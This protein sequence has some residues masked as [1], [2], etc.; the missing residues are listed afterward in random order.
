MNLYRIYLLILLAVNFM[1]SAN[2]IAQINAKKVFSFRQIYDSTEGIELYDKFNPVAGGDSIRKDTTGHPINIIVEDHYPDGNILHKGSYQ[3]GITLYYT[4]FY[5]DG[6]TERTFRALSEKKYEMK[7]YYQN[8]LL[9]SDLIFYESKTIYW[10]EYYPNNQLSYCEEYD[11]KHKQLLKR[12]SYYMD[13]KPQ[14]LFVPLP[15]SKKEKLYSLKDYFTNGQ[16]EED[17]LFYYNPETF[18]FVKHGE[19]KEYDESGK[20]I[21]DIEYVRGEVNQ[22][23]K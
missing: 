6:R 22:T 20:L 3:N 2:S 8:S 1:F 17:A 10:C 21:S 14:S 23:I 13:G 16:M 5:P 15:E 11:K 19:D 18:D 9:K 4:N 7:K 12:C